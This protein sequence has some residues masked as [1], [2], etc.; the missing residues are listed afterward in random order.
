MT[1]CER[2]TALSPMIVR[3]PSGMP[4]N[5]IPITTQSPS[6]TFTP[7]STPGWILTLLT[8]TSPLAHPELAEL[9]HEP[10]LH[11]PPRLVGLVDRVQELERRPSLD[12]VHGTTLVLVDAAHDVP[13]E[14]RMAERVGLGIRSVLLE[15]LLVLGRFRVELP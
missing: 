8:P 13:Q 3:V 1:V 6:S 4:W 15:D 11:R 12:A 14:L 5:G 2:I 9:R 10:Q 7:S